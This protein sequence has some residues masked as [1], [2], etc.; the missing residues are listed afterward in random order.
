MCYSVYVTA[1]VC[2]VKE[3][4]GLSM[5]FMLGEGTVVLRYGGAARSSRQI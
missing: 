4:V 1:I 5:V 3:D 2:V